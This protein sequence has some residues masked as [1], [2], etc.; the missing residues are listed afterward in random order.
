VSGRWDWRMDE[1]V[2]GYFRPD[3]QGTAFRGGSGHGGGP[4][5][6]S[7][8]HMGIGFLSPARGPRLSEGG[9]NR[10]VLGGR[11]ATPAAPA[12]R[13]LGRPNGACGG[14]AW[15]GRKRGWGGNGPGGMVFH[16]VAGRKRPTPVGRSVLRPVSGPSFARGPFCRRDPSPLIVG[17]PPTVGPTGTRKTS[18]AHRLRPE[19]R[20]TQGG[21]PVHPSGPAEYGATRIPFHRGGDPTICKR[22]KS[23][24]MPG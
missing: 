17:G 2:R 7:A 6:A 12:I 4:G 10:S 5:N 11:G 19:A 21:M 24:L 13:E 15:V 3:F 20:G 1:A 23:V 16:R 22:T 14:Q 8:G 18:T 9:G